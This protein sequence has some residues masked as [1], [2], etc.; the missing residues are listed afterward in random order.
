MR[1]FHAHFAAFHAQDA[2]GLVAELEDVTR[3]RLDREVLVHA[4]DTQALRLQHHVIVGG[5]RDCAAR[6]KRSHPC[7]A[8]RAQLAVHRIAMQVGRTDATPRAVALGQH[9]HDV[10]E[11][12]AG[13]RAIRIC[14]SGHVEQFRLAAFAAGDFRHDLLRQHVQG[15]GRD[16]QRVE[17]ATAH[18]IEQRR[19]FDQVI[20]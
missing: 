9:P 11:C 6:G 19:A 12:F 20:A 15:R 3:D 17:L 14:A 18:G 10:G 1:I 5:V 7:A 16:V 13:E 2:I 4:A 8:P